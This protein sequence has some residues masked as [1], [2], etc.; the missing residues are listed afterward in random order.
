MDK[1]DKDT[2]S[3]GP[4][5]TPEEVM[6]RVFEMLAED[7]TNPEY[8]K[9]AKQRALQVRARVPKGFQAE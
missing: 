2:S 9:E 5:R 1:T 8:R 3:R 4:A 7:E 6:A